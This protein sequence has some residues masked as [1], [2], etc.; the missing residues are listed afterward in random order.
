MLR[1]IKRLTQSQP[2]QH[3]LTLPF[4]TR[5]KARFKTPLDDGTEAGLF[6]DRGI[7]LRGGDLLQGEDG[8]VVQ[9][10]AAVEEVSCVRCPD[11]LTLARVCYHLGNR[12]VPLQINTDR[13]YYQ[14]DHVLDDLV[15]GLG[16][17][18]VQESAR[19]EPEAGA[20]QHASEHSHSHHD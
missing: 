12:H 5:Q 14:R 4:E 6:L 18:A 9:V 15:H 3:T 7:V 20:Y 19:F 1:L 17:T 10:L 16:L 11:P 8:S 13:V 2:A